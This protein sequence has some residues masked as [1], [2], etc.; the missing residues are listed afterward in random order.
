MTDNIQIHLDAMPE[1]NPEPQHFKAVS[2]PRAEP[3]AGQVLCKTL[4]LSLDPYMRSQMAGR[5]MSGTINPGDLMRGE[6]VSEVI[7]SKHE[8]FKTGD[9]VRCFGNW[10]QYSVHDAQE[11]TK[12]SSEIDPASYGLS[13]LG[14]PGLTAYAGIVWLANAK[15]GDVVVISAATGAV[16]STAGQLAKI[17]GCTVVGIAGSDS[18]CQHAVE[19]LGYDACINRKTEDLGER[20][21]E[22]C[23]DGVD[24]YF[25]LVGGETLNL[26]CTKL[27][28]NARVILCGLMADYNS[29]TR[30]PGPLPGPLIGAR[31]TLYGLVVYDWEHR[32][33]EFVEACLGHIRAG[34]LSMQEDVSDGIAS[35]ADAFCRLMRGEN[36]GK[37][38]VNVGR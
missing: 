17:S 27:A 22:L 25:D 7:E 32:R 16:G 14:M 10:Q 8:D 36:E 38:I 9:I 19:Q 37:V 34:Q 5:H 23:P 29:K 18:K 20:L 11:V 26:I 3:Q 4:Y 2:V 28:L 1:G 35:A 21:A 33:A 24:V 12:Q 13:V 30:T 15:A 31:A 6:T